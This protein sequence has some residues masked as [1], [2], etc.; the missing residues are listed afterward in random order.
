MTPH[1]NNTHY[2][3]LHHH[4]LGEEPK[5][6]HCSPRRRHQRC[7]RL[8]PQPAA[9]CTSGNPNSS[10]MG[11]CQQ[12]AH[13]SSIRLLRRCFGRT[14]PSQQQ[15]MKPPILTTL[16]GGLASSTAS[17]L[18]QRLRY[19]KL[20]WEHHLHSVVTEITTAPRAPTRGYT[21]MDLVHLLANTGQAHHHSRNTQGN[22]TSQPPP[23]PHIKTG[24][25]TRRL[26]EGHDAKA[27]SPHVH[28]G[29][30]FH[31]GIPMLQ[32]KDPSM[33]ASILD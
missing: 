22:S 29:L 30:G 24:L 23:L 15:Y 27:T 5:E 11:Y 8:K 20:L 10:T 1:T 19:L 7:A 14:H 2:K 33:V 31:P 12:A 4:P 26:Q 18:C 13:R 9:S 21:P 3:T 25:Q 16:R 32:E 6:S 28:I 17:F